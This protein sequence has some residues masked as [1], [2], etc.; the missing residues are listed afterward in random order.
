LL[1]VLGDQ[2]APAEDVRVPFFGT[3]VPTL[4]G[5]ARLAL[6]T[7]APILFLQP[8]ERTRHGYRCRFHSVPFED[9]ADASPANVRELT[10]RHT[11]VLE[12]AI[13]ECP[14]LWLWQHKRWKY[15]NDRP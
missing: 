3:A 11:A 12:A 14:E 6:A 1:A 15:M 5:T 7:R 4:E 9:L 8:L 13:R 2:A 10:A